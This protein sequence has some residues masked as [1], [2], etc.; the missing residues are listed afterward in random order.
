MANHHDLFRVRGDK[1]ARHVVGLNLFFGLLEGL[2]VRKWKVDWYVN[3]C[4]SGGLLE[5]IY[6]L[7]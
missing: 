7:V 5:L 6:P 3:F 2:R 4:L 1:F